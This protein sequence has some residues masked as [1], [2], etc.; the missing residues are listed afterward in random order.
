MNIRRLLATLI[1]LMLAA[2]VS[3]QSYHIRVAKNT[4]LRASDSLDSVVLTSARAGTTVKVLGHRDRWLR[5]QHEGREFWMAAWVSHS[6]VQAPTPAAPQADV[7][8]C[9]DVNRQCST[10]QDWVD[11]YWAYQRNECPVGP[12]SEATSTAQPVAA[13]PAVVDNCCFV[14]RQCQNDQQWTDGYWAYQNNQCGAPTQT[15]TATQPAGSASGQVNNCC[16]IGWQCH[17]DADWNSGYQ[18]YQENQCDNP[19]RQAALS[20][21]IPEGVDNCCF[22]NRQCNTEEEWATGWHVFQHFQCNIPPPTQGISIQGSQTFV[23]QVSNALH[24]LQDRA[25]Q[26]WKYSTSGLNVIKMVAEGSISAVY[27]DSKTYQDT[28]SEVMKDGTGEAG[29]VYVIFGIVHEACHVHE[30]HRFKQIVEEEKACMEASLHALQ[31]VNPADRST[32]EWIKWIIANIYDP[33][34]QWW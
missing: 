14:D 9:C 30:G 15:L 2:V 10:N 19:Q 6:R 13:A 34:V 24:L 25:P 5:V 22:V 23:T 27:V 26:W 28:L 21:V 31:Q 17:N 11:G 8:N 12:T 33:E 20:V 18:A 3:A 4:N 7:N 32:I 29:L 16:F 1:P